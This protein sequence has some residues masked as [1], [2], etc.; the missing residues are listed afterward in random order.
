MLTPLLLDIQ[1]RGLPV[2]ISGE[3]DS[4]KTT[5]A[6]E[7]IS[8]CALQYLLVDGERTMPNRFPSAL[9]IRPDTVEDAFSMI[10]T[11]LKDT[12]INAVLFDSIVSLPSKV[13]EYGSQSNLY[14]TIAKGLREVTPILWESQKTMIWVNQMRTKPTEPP[15]EYTPG[16]RTP[17]LTAQTRIQLRKIM[18]H[19]NGFTSQVTVLKTPSSFRLKSY[20]MRINY[21]AGIIMFN[22]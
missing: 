5:L 16:G 21:G 13:D 18:T 9:V 10:S 15:V 17:Y 4:G 22:E 1:L 8:T 11:C 2:E 12:N 6:L 7:L 3:S 14:R 19:Q 20:L